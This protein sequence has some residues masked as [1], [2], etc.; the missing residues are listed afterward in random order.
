MSDYVSTHVVNEITMLCDDQI[1]VR[2]L[3][4]LIIFNN[5]IYSLK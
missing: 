4:G 2:F 5:I 1:K 3:I